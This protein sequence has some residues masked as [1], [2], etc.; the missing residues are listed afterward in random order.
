MT[1]QAFIRHLYLSGI[2]M[3]GA[4]QKLFGIPAQDCRKDP[5]QTGIRAGLFAVIM[6]CSPIAQ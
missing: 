6:F 2:Y 3:E 4:L 5:P 1:A